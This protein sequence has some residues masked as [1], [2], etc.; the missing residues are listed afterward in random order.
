MQVLVTGGTGFIGRSL[1]PQLLA[2]PDTAVILLRHENESGQPLPPPLAADQDR[3]DVVYADLRNF[4]LTVRAVREARPDAII[5]LAAAG[6]TAPFLPVDVALRHNVT[7][8]V[9]LLRACF[10]K[11]D[12]TSQ[13][14]VARTPR[15]VEPDER[16]RRQ[17]SS[18]LE[19]LSD[20]RPYPGLAHSRRDDLSSLRVRTS[21]P[22]PSSRRPSGRR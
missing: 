9:N 19:L 1:I 11:C 18:R 22:T 20:V 2:R 4:K 16:V 6:T 3:L 5:H 10:E 12:T 15:R 7:G 17:Q 8:T 13:I 21:R 14:I